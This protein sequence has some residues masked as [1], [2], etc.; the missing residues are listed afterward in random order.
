MSKNSHDSRR[1][2][3]WDNSFSQKKNKRQWGFKE[4]I[5]HSKNYKNLPK[6]LADRHQ[7]GIPTHSIPLADDD[8]PDHPKFLGNFTVGHRWYTFLRVLEDRDRED[9]AGYIACFY[10]TYNF[11]SRVCHNLQILLQSRSKHHIIHLNLPHTCITMYS[12]YCF[13]TKQ[14]KSKNTP[15]KEKNQ[16]HK[17]SGT[18]HWEPLY[19]PGLPQ[20]TTFLL[21]SLQQ[22]D[23][24]QRWAHHWMWYL[25]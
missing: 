12:L 8:T 18:S 20:S 4:S 24:T 22:E 11:L 23:G 21:H 2:K 19:R 17:A 14:R 25:R 16:C 5:R 10:S 3:I 15:K 6:P 9:V 7:S 13:K 1:S